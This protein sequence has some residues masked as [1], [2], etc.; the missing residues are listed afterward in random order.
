LFLGMFT[1]QQQHIMTIMDILRS[2]GIV[3]RDDAGA[4]RFA[5]SADPASNAELY[6][7]V[8]ATYIRLAKELGIAVPPDL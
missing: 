2:H 1:K 8:K 6:G 4:F 5:R 7:D 3:T